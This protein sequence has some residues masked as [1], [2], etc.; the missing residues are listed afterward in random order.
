MSITKLRNKL[1]LGDCLEVLKKLPDNSIDAVIT[2]P[3]YGISFLGKDWDKAIPPIGVWEECLRVLKDGAFAFIMSSPRQDVQ[4]RMIQNLE[5][6][7]FNIGFT[8]IY[9]AYA[10]GFPKAMNISKAID[11]KLGLER[12][13]VAEV[14]PFGR[15]RRKSPIK[16]FIHTYGGGELMS[17]KRIITTPASK[18]SKV[19]D[20]SYAGYQ[21]KPAIEVIIVAMKPLDEKTFVE[22]AIK[23][24]KGITWLDDCRI[25]VVDQEEYEYNAKGRE[26]LKADFR[27]I[28][29][30]GY[31]NPKDIPIVFDKGRFPANLIAS[32]NILD[33]GVERESKWGTSKKVSQTATPFFVEGVKSTLDSNKFTG[34][35]GSFSR[36]FDLDLW[37][38]DKF[39]DLPPDVQKTFPFLIVAKSS[40][41]E[42]NKGAEHFKGVETK[43][44]SGEALKSKKER[45][46]YGNFHPTVKPIKLMSYLV[47]LATRK[48]D[49]VLDPYMG[50]GT[51][52]IACKINRRDYVGC[53]INKEWL[54]IALARLNAVKRSF[55]LSKL[56]KKS[57]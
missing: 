19:L 7:G 27:P 43:F 26:R 4:F 1:V 20:G 34:D 38:K 15:E 24:G 56:V 5:T 47:I 45:D 25:P 3:P 21:P 22:Q 10:S 55:D 36:Y 29:E 12:E 8:P 49:L 9:W 48:G 18:K 28:H 50:S 54:Q 17:S 33:D 14:E 53:D 30:G 13:V 57:K 40:K 16:G 23:T 37:F 44:E 46:V 32:D 39:K 6:A 41:S 31:K 52:A 11:K 42:R 51:T 35:R 2:D